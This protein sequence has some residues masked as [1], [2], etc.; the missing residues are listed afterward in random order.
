MSNIGLRITLAKACAL[1]LGHLLMLCDI[2][3]YFEL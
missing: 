1:L 3:D 2:A